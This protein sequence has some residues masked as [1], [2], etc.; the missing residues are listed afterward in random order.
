[1]KNVKQIRVLINEN[2]INKLN[3]EKISYLF[4]DLLD[5]YFSIR[6][7]GNEIKNL[8]KIKEKIKKSLYY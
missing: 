3:D 5:L 6:D 1:M 7:N 8:I 4:N 2:K